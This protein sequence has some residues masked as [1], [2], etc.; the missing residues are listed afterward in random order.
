[1]ASVTVREG[2]TRVQVSERALVSPGRLPGSHRASLNP[3][4]RFRTSLRLDR[5]G[6][7][8]TPTLGND[9]DETRRHVATRDAG[10]VRLEVIDRIEAPVTIDI[11]FAEGNRARPAGQKR[12]ARESTDVK[13]T[14]SV[15]SSATRSSA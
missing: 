5:K 9:D 12:T 15:A 4:S 11:L 6:P 2:V 7:R 1:M 3:F 8:E 13:S 10:L 14:L